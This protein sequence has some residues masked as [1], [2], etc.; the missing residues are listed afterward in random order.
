VHH[1]EFP[2][3]SRPA[4]SRD[5]RRSAATQ[6]SL[7][8]LLSSQSSTCD[9]HMLSFLRAIAHRIRW[10]KSL[11]KQGREIAAA[12]LLA[13][14]D[15]GTLIVNRTTADFATAHCWWTAE[16]V[17]QIAPCPAPDDEQRKTLQVA[18]PPRA[19]QFDQWCYRRYISTDTGTATLVCPVYNGARMAELLQKSKPRMTIVLSWS[20]VASAEQGDGTA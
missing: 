5:R 19:H 15:T 12:S 8:K 18:V 14:H 6:L 20:A 2:N 7:R 1:A 16:N 11:R 10:L 4:Q 3:E 9:L 13:S 17:L